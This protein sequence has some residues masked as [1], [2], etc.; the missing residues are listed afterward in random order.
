MLLQ[1]VMLDVEFELCCVVKYKVD[2]IFTGSFFLST[3][4]LVGH[5]LFCFFLFRQIF[6][7][8]N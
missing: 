4:L 6:R 5:L 2:Y 8:K 1:S 3:S 7:R